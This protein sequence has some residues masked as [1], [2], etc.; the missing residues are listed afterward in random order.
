MSIVKHATFERKVMQPEQ[1]GPLKNAIDVCIT[2]FIL[3]YA[4]HTIN[5]WQSDDVKE[6]Q[7]PVKH[8][9]RR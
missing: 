6:E 2:S 1:I 3:H 8:V 4:T 9:G 5:I 7:N